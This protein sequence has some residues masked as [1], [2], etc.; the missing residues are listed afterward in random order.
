MFRFRRSTVPEVIIDG[1]ANIGLATL[2]FKRSTPSTKVIAIEADPS[3]VKILRENVER[4]ELENVE[5]VEGAL[6]D[7]LEKV[8]FAPDQADGGSVVDSKSESLAV[9]T[10]LLSELIGNRSID[11]LKLDIEG[12]EQRVLEE[13]RSSLERV[14]Q[15]YVEYHSPRN[16]QQDLS[17]VLKVLEDSG[18]HYYIEATSIH[19]GRPFS[20]QFPDGPYGPQCSIFGWRNR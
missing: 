4:F 6:W 15:V 8:S 5:I 18:F 11:F 14:E 13:A 12:A 10:L 16:E 3:I 7:V 20:D 17:R 9:S 19:L 1:G 2:Y